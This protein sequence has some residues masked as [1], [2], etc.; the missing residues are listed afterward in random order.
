[1]A[2]TVKNIRLD[3]E[4]ISKITAI[5]ERDHHGNFT[6]A[7]ES[8]ANQAILIRGLDTL[9]RWSMYDSVKQSEYERTEAE[10]GTPNVRQ[11]IDA[12]HI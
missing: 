6:A 2:K 8:L 4:L 10:T 11:L 5:A 1:M 12:L 7:I 9:T 3:N